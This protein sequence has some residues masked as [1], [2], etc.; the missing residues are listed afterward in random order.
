MNYQK[1]LSKAWQ[2]TWKHKYL[3][4]F[5]FLAGLTIGGGDNLNR[6]IQGGTWLFQIIGDIMVFQGLIAIL[7]LVVSLVF[8][9]LGIVA[10]CSLIYEV[11][12]LGSGYKKPIAR[13]G[14]LFS[15]GVKFL[16]RILLMQLLIWFPVLVLSIAASTVGQPAS[17]AALSDVEAGTSELADVGTLGALGLL[18]C[19]FALL[20]IPVTIVDAIAYRAIVLEELHVTSSIRRALEVI[21]AN[22]G[23]IFILAVIC[24]V[25]AW[26]FSLIL[27][28]VLSPLLLIMAKPILQGASQCAEFGSDL[29]AMAD[30][31]QWIGANPPLMLLSVAVSIVAAALSSVW[32]TFQS[33]VFTLA[34]KQFS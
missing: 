8:W 28:I 12:A 4:F 25:L 6:F 3:W 19:S 14:N 21:K 2:I 29:K 11:T 15:V 32:V 26:V 5:G 1:I 22:L 9:L 18:G 23:Q 31:I 33:A 34:Y 7:V 27:G 16:P 10:R 24:L 30:C 17:E 20:A 13:I